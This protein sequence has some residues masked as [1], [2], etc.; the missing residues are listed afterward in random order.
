MQQPQ[1]QGQAEMQAQPMAPQLQ[2]PQTLPQQ[3]QPQSQPQ[4]QQT[5]KETKEEQP[6]STHHCQIGTNLLDKPFFDSWGA[7][8]RRSKSTVADT[9]TQQAQPIASSAP[10]ILTPSTQPVDESL[11]RRLA[12][13]ELEK[14]PVTSEPYANVSRMR[15]FM[16]KLDANSTPSNASASAPKTQ[17]VFPSPIGSQAVDKKPRPRSPSPTPPI[18][19]TTEHT[20]PKISHTQSHTGTPFPS[21]V[22]STVESI[23]PKPTRVPQPSPIQSKSFAQLQPSKTPVSSQPTKA[24]TSASLPTQTPA[25]TPTQTPA[26]TP[27][28]TQTPSS[29]TQPKTPTASQA[30]LMPCDSMT[31]KPLRLFLETPKS[32]PPKLSKAG[33]ACVPSLEE[34]RAMTDEQLRRVPKFSVECPEHGK[35]CFSDPV[36]LRGLDLD[37]VVEFQSNKLTMYPRGNKPRRGEGLNR[38]AVITLYRC[39]PSE[40]K[41]TPPLLAKYK[42]K[43]VRTTATSGAR[44]ISYDE[45][46][47]EWVF[48]VDHF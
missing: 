7:R 22:N 8:L 5:R 25:Q 31:G 4:S 3:P 10:T 46:T 48:S 15:H 2:V 44:L 12:N 36:D 20:T 37:P 29:A 32:G 43:I 21:R 17:S 11:S 39:L 23:T 33:Y 19:P 30:K 28:P 45:N 34:L 6:V 35:I 24:P 38:P 41:R 14:W 1:L 26:Q 16:S 13:L 47:G 18:S 42:E 27:T 40:E 9:S